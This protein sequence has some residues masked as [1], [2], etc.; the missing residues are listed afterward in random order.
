MPRPDLARLTGTELLVLAGFGHR[1]TARTAATYRHEVFRVS[2]GR[3]VGEMT[4][5]QATDFALSHIQKE[6]A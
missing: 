3:V 5:H 6:A 4:A 1:R 2:D